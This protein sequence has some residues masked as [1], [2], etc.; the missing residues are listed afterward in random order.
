MPKKSAKPKP[1]KRAR[2][3]QRQLK[4]EPPEE[5]RND[6]RLQAALDE[7]RKLKDA[8][9]KLP[10]PKPE[11]EDVRQWRRDF[12][13]ADRAAPAVRRKSRVSGP[14][15]LS[16]Q[17]L[18]DAQDYYDGLLNTNDPKWRNQQTA[19]KHITVHFLKL[20]EESW[21]TVE[22]QVVVPK[23]IERGL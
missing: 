21:Q 17:Q 6:P 10:Q 8:L 13:S 3:P 9:A 11:H 15:L 2:K 22:D 12:D 20:P 19:A 23:L 14:R 1:R 16:D 4:Y 5:L 18:K 7:E